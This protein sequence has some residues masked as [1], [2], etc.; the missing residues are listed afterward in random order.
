MPLGLQWIAGHG[1]DR[2]MLSA[3]VELCLVLGAG[4][5]ISFPD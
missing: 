5:R 1:A 4:Q 3:C 2:A